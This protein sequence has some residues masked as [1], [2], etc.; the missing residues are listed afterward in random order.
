[1]KE[2]SLLM[3]VYRQEKTAYLDNCFDSI[4]RQ[5]VLPAEIILVEDGP[6]TTELYESIERQ[7]KRLPM[8][9]RIVLEENKG[10]G[11]AL[12]KGMEACSCDIVARMDTDDICVDDRFE[13]QMKYMEEHPEV[14]VLGAWITEFDHVPTNVVGI[15][16]VPEDNEEIY[17]FGKKR[18]PIN[19][20]VVM[21]RKKAVMETGGYM[22]C[23]LFEDYFLWARMLMKGYVFHNLQQP[24]LLFRR[25]PD[26]I[27]RRGGLAYACHEILFLLKL[28]ELGYISTFGMLRNVSQRT[29]VRILPNGVR[30][31]IY[32]YLLRTIP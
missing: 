29:I 16:T 12:N 6:L 21:F 13:V 4:C 14:D 1:M 10:L 22:P 31:F 5:S 24:L 17:S 30:S 26:M 7:Q 32:K 18:N 23:Y 8:M 11:V 20:P 25:S 15:R 2:F 3:S 27:R 28:R 19:H 9:K